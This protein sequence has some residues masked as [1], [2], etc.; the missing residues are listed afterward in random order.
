MVVLAGHRQHGGV[1]VDLAAVQA[2]C[3]THPQ[4]GD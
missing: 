3:L 2:E 1:Q 4:R